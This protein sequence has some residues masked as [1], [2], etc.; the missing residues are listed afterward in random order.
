VMA[1]SFAE[2]DRVIDA[3]G[4]RE[5]V[6]ELGP[7]A[8]GRITHSPGWRWSTDIR[9]IVGTERCQSRHVGCV[10]SGR[11]GFEL[12]DGS[13]GEVGPGGVYDIAPGHDGW[14]IGDEPAVVI[15]WIG[16][17]EWLVPRHG[18][19]ILASLLFT[20]IVGSTDHAARIGDRAWRAL[21]SAHDETVRELLSAGH[22]REVARAGDGFLAVFDSPARAIQTAI[23]LRDRLRSLGLE[24]RQGIHVGEIEISAT[25]ARGLAVHEAAR[26][27]AA[28]GAGEILVSPVTR[29]LAAGSG[30]AF[31]SRGTYELKGFPGTTELFAV[32]R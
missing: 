11:L 10:V 27:M 19:R 6:V 15:E 21:L 25:D 16:V 26:V 32:E 14:V 4:V 18:E 28:A 24:L 7:V 22:G 2:P 20:D 5:E 1:R 17:L 31:S 30:Y 8:I 12:A 9:P 13:V 23:L 29:T 3:P